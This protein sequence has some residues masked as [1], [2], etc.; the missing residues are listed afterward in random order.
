MASEAVGARQVSVRIPFDAV[1]DRASLDAHVANAGRLFARDDRSFPPGS[2]VGFS[3]VC[4]DGTVVAKGT[5]R[6]FPPAGDAPGVDETGAG[7]W[8]EVVAL[9]PVGAAATPCVS[10]PPPPPETEATLSGD[11]VIEE[12]VERARPAMPGDAAKSD[13]AREVRFGKYKILRRLGTGG[14]AEVF[15]A[16][17][18]GIGG[19]EKAVVIKRILPDRIEEAETLAMFLDEARLAA[20]LT[21]PNIVQTFEV[22]EAEGLP[23]LALEFVDGQPFSR[24]LKAQ[25]GS[26]VDV[27]V[28]IAVVADVCKALHY[29]HNARDADGR[30][31]H[32]VHRDVTP[33][34][35]VVAKDGSVKL[36]D[37]GVA[38]ASGRRIVTQVGTI[39]G[40]LAY[41]APE[42]FAGE[43]I[44]HRADV[45]SAGVCLYEATTGRRPF[46]GKTDAEL[47]RALIN[48]DYP[49]PSEVAQ[50]YPPDLEKIVQ[51]AMAWNAA[52]RCPSAG[53]LAEALEDFLSAN[54]T[55]IA[56]KRDIADWYTRLKPTSNTGDGSPSQ[57]SRSSSR[58][59]SAP[60]GA[61][62]NALPGRPAKSSSAP[63]MTGPVVP[64]APLPPPPSKTGLFVGLGLGVVAVVAGAVFMLA[65]P[66]GAPGP[67]THTGQDV[68]ARVRALLDSAQ[69]QLDTKRVGQAMALL[70]RVQAETNVGPDLSVRAG[71]MMNRVEHDMALAN[72]RTLLETGEIEKALDAAKMA[73]DR[74]PD[75]TDARAM[76]TDIVKRR[77]GTV[78]ASTGVGTTPQPTGVGALSVTTTPPATVLVDELPFGKAPFV[79]RSLKAGKHVLEVRLAGYFAERREFEVQPGQAVSLQVGLRADAAPR[80]AVV[81]FAVPRHDPKKE[82]EER[83]KADEEAKRRTDE[84][85]AAQVRAEADKRAADEAQAQEEAARKKKQAEEEDAARRATAVEAKAKAAA[86]APV[87][88][89]H[90]PPRLPATYLARNVKDIGRVLSLIE[91]EAVDRGRLS[92]ERVRG[93]TQELLK[94]L[95]DNFNPGQT[96]DFN[97]LAIY[98]LILAGV[99]H[100]R[101]AADVGHEL[102]TKYFDGGLQ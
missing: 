52:E 46:V 34:N 3:C 66:A 63:K 96:V 17:L 4:D 56:D 100:G 40:K 92:P 69:T 91:K 6:V 7:L 47:M 98:E 23:Y 67:G 21:H 2:E 65:R 26:G 85:Q 38:K 30:A 28:G 10:P 37:F 36:L 14:M 70:K 42:Q 102:R 11:V 31:L 48:E 16:R 1:T 25:A 12:T 95:M 24:L 83:R 19:F 53:A 54:P 78:T 49:A 75:S 68:D 59:R 15:E 82:A 22:G 5:G 97:P 64:A 71:L 72:A 101:T 86:A 20:N 44:D 77:A 79:D 32:I 99:E 41:M 88:V 94:A 45:F 18:T 13:P 43:D 61:T 93:T 80:A 9:A 60:T 76:L 90:L 84:E 8:L 57:P 27:G 62:R 39:K 58:P 35:I 81:P 87:R 29:A 89:E 73:L 74:D 55:C 33:H 50:D 51:W